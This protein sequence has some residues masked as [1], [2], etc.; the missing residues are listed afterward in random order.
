MLDTLTIARRLRTVGFTE[1]QADAVTEALRDAA[2]MPDISRLVTKDDLAVLRAELKGDIKT[3]N[4]DLLKII[5]SAL[6][7]NVGATVGL[8]KLIH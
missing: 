8:I 1:N 3:A 7:I 2:N 6:V 4:Y 5:L